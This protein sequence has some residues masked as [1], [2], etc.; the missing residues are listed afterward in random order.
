MAA[1]KSSLFTDLSLI[2]ATATFTSVLCRQVKPYLE[3]GVTGWEKLPSHVHDRL[4]ME[5]ASV[6]ARITL[7]LVILPIICKG[8]AALE[9]WRRSDTEMCLMVW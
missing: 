6:P 3:R 8:F 5:L 4:A 7:G 9:E 1:S 2:T